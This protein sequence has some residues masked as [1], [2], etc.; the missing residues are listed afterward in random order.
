M[1][2][3]HSITET[4]LTL[5]GVVFYAYERAIPNGAMLPNSEVL[6]DTA[7]AVATAEQSGDDVALGLAR[8]TRGVALVHRDGPVREQG[9]EL[10]ALARDMAL[11]EQYTMTEIPLIDS[12]TAQERARLGDLDGAIEL[13][14][15]VAGQLL[16]SGG[17]IWTAFATAV[18]VEALLRRRSGADLRG[19][20]ASDR[21]L[22]R[23]AHR[24]GISA[25]RDPA[26]ADAS[27]IGAG[28]R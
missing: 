21:S 1:T 3:S 8:I 25:A 22:R 6:Q 20:E 27:S 26:A 17:A 14:R 2:P 18:F 12:Y 28:V 13:S 23:G 7:Q 10:L 9:I 11:R 15:T 24:P 19:G 4:S 5:A 16:D